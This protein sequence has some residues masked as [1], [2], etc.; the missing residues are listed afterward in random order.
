MLVTP[1]DDRVEGLLHLLRR[2]VF[3]EEVDDPKTINLRAILARLH[4]NVFAL[5]VTYPK[6]RCHE[7]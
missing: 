5:V 6:A 7:V 3:C 4:S 1:V 2:V